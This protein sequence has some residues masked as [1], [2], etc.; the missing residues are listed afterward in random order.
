MHKTDN[1]N[2]NPNLT[3]VMIIQLLMKFGWDIINGHYE[4]LL[5]ICEG[6]ASALS[7]TRKVESKFSI[8][9]RVKNIFRQYLI[10]LSLE[11]LLYYK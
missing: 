9:N 11:G 6:L 2:F 4:F 8:L 3:R 5:E 1:R 10:N 7:L